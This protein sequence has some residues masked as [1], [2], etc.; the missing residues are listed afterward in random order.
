MERGQEEE[1]EEEKNKNRLASDCFK[2]GGCSVLKLADPGSCLTVANNKCM[3]SLSIH[4]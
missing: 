4:V 3:N 1:E 2:G